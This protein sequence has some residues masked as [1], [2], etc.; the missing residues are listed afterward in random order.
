M[1]S[2]ND[3]TPKNT[4]PLIGVVKRQMKNQVQVQIQ[5]LVQ[6]TE[7]IE[8]NINFSCWLLVVG[9]WLLVVG[10]WLLVVGCWLLET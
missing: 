1:V 7:K 4:L 9:C 2:I 6:K 3:N 10:C 8:R 5:V